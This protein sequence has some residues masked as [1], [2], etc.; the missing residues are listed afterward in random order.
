MADNKIVIVE[1]PTGIGKSAIALAL[2]A[3][4]ADNAP[5]HILTG[6][7][8][9]QEQYREIDA[10]ALDM[11][12]VT[13]RNN[14]P[15]AIN[16][17]ETAATAICTVGGK[18]E[19][20]RT[21]DCAYYRQRD[22]AATAPLSVWNYA[23]WLY[24]LNYTFVFPKPGLLICD[25]AHDL[26]GQLRSFAKVTFS[27]RQIGRLGL[28]L[29]FLDN[30][31]G[32]LEWCEENYPAIQA[33]KPHKVSDP[34]DTDAKS[35]NA[36]LNGV[37]Q[38][39]SAFTKED[40]DNW[41][42]RNERW[43]WEASPVWVHG[44]YKRNLDQH[45]KKVVMFSA[46][47]LDAE[48]FCYQLGIDSA[49]CV[50]V[51]SPFPVEARPFYYAPVGKVKRDNPEVV[52]KLC[53]A[54][55]HLARKHTNERGL[56]H[57]TSYK[58]A[59]AIAQGLPPD[60]SSR[61][62]EHTSATRMD[63]LSTYRQTQGAILLSPSMSTGIDLPYDLCRWQVITK[64]PF[65]DLGDE[66]TKR[67]MKIG[68]DGE[69]TKRGQ[70]W[71]NWATA[72]ALVQAYGRGCRAEDDYAATYLLDGTWGWFRHAIKDM[73]PVWV[74]DAQRSYDLPSVDKRSAQTADDIL[75]EIAA[76]VTR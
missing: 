45:A 11:R 59:K 14:W 15:C 17:Q 27:R 37:K 20:Q 3:L 75:K 57:T 22:L 12:T 70:H 73:W 69:P 63:A 18:C 5:T 49:A 2:H 13:G 41:I 54:I 19:L 58:L 30:V 31:E 65:P 39:V 42:M 53:T 10:P 24:Q 36:A 56:I 55:T 66:Q 23:Y 71:Y 21:P 52:E 26:E 72:C 29:P 34:S 32:W 7:K 35:W 50:T 62:L 48:Q 74:K 60:V 68:P 6:T 76:I 61:L 9:L 16:P 64:L 43:G 25:E 51:P 38:A 44:F 4:L 8:Q 47:V 67:R 28:A 33:L 46:T 1:A 40:P